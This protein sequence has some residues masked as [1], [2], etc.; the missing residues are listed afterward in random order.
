MGDAVLWK[1]F[2]ENELLEELTVEDQA[3]GAYH[4]FYRENGT[5][6]EETL[7]GAEVQNVWE[8]GKRYFPEFDFY[9]FG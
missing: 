7:A 9:N 6:R 3:D 5:V 8:I 1:Y 2:K 4:V